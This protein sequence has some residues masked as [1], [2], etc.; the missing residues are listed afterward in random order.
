MLWCRVQSR[1]SVEYSGRCR[2]HGLWRRWRAA[3]S[4]S[5]A[6]H[7][8]LLAAEL[9]VA[10][11]THI[12]VAAQV[13]AAPF[14]RTRLLSTL[15]WQQARSVGMRARAGCENARGILPSLL[16]GGFGRSAER[17]PLSGSGMAV[18]RRR[19]LRLQLLH[20]RSVLVACVDASGCSP[21]CRRTRECCQDGGSSRPCRGIGSI[22]LSWRRNVL[23]AQWHV[24]LQA[25]V[26][27]WHTRRQGM[28]A[29]S[30]RGIVRRTPISRRVAARH[31]CDSSGVRRGGGGRW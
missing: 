12:C 22:V 7:A 23:R 26:P 30:A 3:R 17:N 8:A 4:P 15:A 1:Q 11:P 27:H 5:E 31:C 18:L 19:L 29:L 13:R 20:R 25:R 9:R 28:E 14:T 16:R 6:P 24:S 2:A 10:L 21:P